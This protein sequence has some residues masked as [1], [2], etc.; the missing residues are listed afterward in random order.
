LRWPGR[1][2]G[3]EVR[4]APAPGAR[5]R[6]A[7]NALRPHARRRRCALTPPPPAPTARRSRPP[8]L[9]AAAP[10]RRAAAPRRAAPPPPRC[11]AEVSARPGAAP[12]AAAAAAAEGGFDFK[13]YMGGRAA[14]V[15]AALDAAVPL[16]HPEA[17][18]AAMRYS[19]L[20]GG[21][22]V[23]PAL[24]LA[25][26]ELV[27]GAAAAALPTACALEM[28]HTMSLIHDDLPSMD[29]DDFRRGVPTCHKAFGEE[30]AILAG[31]ALLAFAF[32]HIARE[33]RGVPAGVVVRVLAEVGRAVGAQGL[34][35]GQVVDIKSE[36]LPPGEVTL[37]TL[38]YIHHHKTAALLEAA[39]VCGALLGGAG[40]ADVE[41]L[42]KYALDVGLAF[43]VRRP[44]FFSF[45]LACSLAR[46]SSS[47]SSR[48]TPRAA[49]L[50]RSST[51]SS[52]AP[53][54]AR[55]WARRRARTPRSPRRPTPR[56]SASSAR[57]RSRTS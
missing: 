7:T 14:E 4:S 33:T 1:A 15:N 28:V 53:R 12:P 40:D 32:E 30:V 22:R 55:S 39:V 21:K 26:A 45:L 3:L 42:R 57:A 31:D 34:V 36:G 38:R 47:F 20:A 41:R 24:C 8:A 46:C 54:R 50:A 52:T 13:A 48:L 2:L 11:A 44:S 51:T 37:E 35:A 16:R 19:L 9:A 49:H 23:R 27:G 25:A 56:S 6:R 10:P 18:T 5:E 29:D 17:V 43:Q